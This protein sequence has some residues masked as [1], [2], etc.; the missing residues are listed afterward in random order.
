MPMTNPN[1]ENKRPKVVFQPIKSWTH[2]F[3]LLSDQISGVTPS[4]NQLSNLKDA[5][6]G[7]KRIVFPDKKA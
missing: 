1:R 3:C 5:G 2:D 6:L 7:R 4:I